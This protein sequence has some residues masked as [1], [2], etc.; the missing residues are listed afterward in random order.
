MI[1]LDKLIDSAAL[2]QRLNA[3]RK[4]V[5][6]RIVYSM[7]Y[8]ICAGVS[9]A[10]LLADTSEN[11]IYRVF[12]FSFF[13]FSLFRL[14][15]TATPR[16]ENIVISSV[17]MLFFGLQ[18]VPGLLEANILLMDLFLSLLLF[19]FFGH[20]PVAEKEIGSEAFL[21]SFLLIT[22]LFFLTFLELCLIGFAIAISRLS[23]LVVVETTFE[24]HLGSLNG[25]APWHIECPIC[26]EDFENTDVIRYLKCRHIFHSGCI[27]EWFNI[28]RCCPLCKND[29]L[30]GN[31]IRRVMS[32]GN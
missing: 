8:T 30:E 32:S 31:S 6:R 15:V 26:K 10:C 12:Q 3:L 25:V 16:A 13:I 24:L 27:E 14:A 5:A 21:R 2:K 9:L 17:D 1:L 22:M 20:R 7:H 4:H 11:S 29:G 19:G 23:Q 28:K 18:Q